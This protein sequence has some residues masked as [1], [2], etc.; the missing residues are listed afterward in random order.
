MAVQNRGL[1]LATDW[2]PIFIQY[3]VLPSEL[4]GGDITLHLVLSTLRGQYLLSSQE[5]RQ[6][7]ERFARIADIHPDDAHALLFTSTQRS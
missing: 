2:N 6:I 1:W 4:V 3:A 7:A 5:S